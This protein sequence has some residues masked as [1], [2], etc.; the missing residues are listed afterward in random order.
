VIAQ[1]GVR[2]PHRLTHAVLV[3]PTRDPAAGGPFQHTLRLAL[4]VPLER[5]ALIAIAVRDYLR[6]GPKLMYRLFREALRQRE[7]DHLRHLRVPTLIVRGSRDP[8]VTQG[9]VE[10][11]NRLVPT[12][13]LV[14]VNGVGH[15][16]NFSAAAR[17][18][19]EIRLFLAEGDT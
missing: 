10:Q 11:I 18:T 12:S 14:V 13:R 5:P 3:G 17:L 19:D 6:A 15:A 8:I 1:L 16:V 2:H 4:D 7:E 9:W